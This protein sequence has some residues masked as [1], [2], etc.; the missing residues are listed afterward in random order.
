[1]ND[2]GMT[3]V[4]S[5]IQIT[6]ILVPAAILHVVASR[7]SPASGSWI[8][9]VGLALSVVIAAANLIPRP[10][11]H[12]GA[13]AVSMAVDVGASAAAVPPA[14]NSHVPYRIDGN[15]ASDTGRLASGMSSTLQGFLIAWRRLEP[16]PIV[17]A[18]RFRRWGGALAVVGIAGAGFGLLRLCV[19]LWAI[20]LCR[21]RGTIVDD[22]HLIALCGEIQLALGCHQEVEI[23]EVPDL[24][25][26]ATAGWRRPVIL[27]PDDWR[28]WDAA[29]RRAVLAHELAHIHRWDYAA[30]LV[31]RLALAVQFYH[32]LVHW[33]ARR[34][35]L[36]Q[37]L[38]ADAIG[39]S[40]AGGTDSYLLSLS[41][42][43]LEQDARSS[44]WLARAF[45]PA[46]RTLIRRIA[47]LQKGT[48]KADK[49]WS[50]S[51]R[52]LAGIG[53]VAITIGVLT[54]RAPARAGEDAQ[55]SQA[56]NTET[57]KTADSARASGPLL[58]VRFFSE[59]ARGLIAFR[60]AT[61]LRRARVPQTLAVLLGELGGE[62]PVTALPVI[63]KELGIDP[64]A[65]GQGVLPLDQIELI[66]ATLGFGQ[67]KVS[68][69]GRPMH[70]VE[71][72][73]PTIRAIRS[74]DWLGF[75]RAWHIPL[76]E[77][78]SVGHTYYQ[79]G[80]PI[81]RYFYGKSP[82]VYLPDSRTIVFKE[83]SE[84]Q[85]TL[86][87]V[88]RAPSFL[89]GT[90]WERANRALMAIVIDNRHGEISEGYDL[91]R[92]DDKLV[93]DLFKNVDHWIFC[94][95]DTDSATIHARATC[96][97]DR[98]EE[99]AGFAESHV[100]MARASIQAR[101][102]GAPA[103]TIHERGWR[104][105]GAVVQ[106]A[107]V[108]HGAR[109]VEVRSEG[110]GTLADLGLVLETIVGQQ[111]AEEA[112]GQSPPAIANGGGQANGTSPPR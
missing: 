62:F 110:F 108:T 94:I 3:L 49:P 73:P 101:P 60:P 76:T 42:L 17:P 24:T 4:W 90:D 95:D 66:I 68:Q 65:P 78:T 2:L 45:L 1:M 70:R 81:K 98:G 59:N 88:K 91:G 92:S 69:D 99:I 16:G 105:L 50:W 5:A 56:P 63:A 34:M 84:L 36:Q 89:P 71:I 23:R 22:P 12:V 55:A 8:A 93:V 39:A 13:S 31:A 58:D 29:D 14:E 30:G 32:P 82:C 52:F 77:V 111:I 25:S 80:G 15:P 61:I 43:T 48:A 106:N 104:L 20:R 38:A 33:L 67:G 40:L 85:K 102:T 112:A 9:T 41:R 87:R 26:P 75:L 54:L 18:A 46:R 109:A 83:E 37:E 74:F 86:G 96:N 21:R 19:G 10:R 28:S 7:R 6:L 72:G 51:V 53:L 107:R 103:S 35:I 100:K 44:C 64:P 27:L 97:A 47:M 79:I 57:Q 11:R